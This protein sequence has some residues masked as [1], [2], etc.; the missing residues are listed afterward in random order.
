MELSAINDKA[1]RNWKN[2]KSTTSTTK[3]IKTERSHRSKGDTRPP[4]VR[5]Q[6]P[7]G[8]SCTEIVY[9]KK[10][11]QYIEKTIEAASPKYGYAGGVNEVR[12]VSPE[13]LKQI[14]SLDRIGKALE[15]KRFEGANTTCRCGLKHK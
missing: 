10:H 2:S 3:S 8:N 9:S 7:R 11:G 13:K 6:R 15:N 4:Q 5:D 1:I 14:E 12:E